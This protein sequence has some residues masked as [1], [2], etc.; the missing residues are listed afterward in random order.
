MDPS[1]PYRVNIIVVNRLF[2]R[3]QPR[4]AALVVLVVLAVLAYLPAQFLPPISDDYEQVSVSRRYGS[5]EN[6]D[7][8]LRDP[9]Y[10]CRSVS[11]V[12]TWWLEKLGGFAIL[13]AL[14]LLFHIL[15]TF[16]V[17]ALGL[18]HRIGWRISLPAAAFF[19][20]AEGHQEAVIWYAALPELNVFTFTMLAFL[21][22]IL[23][24]ERGGARY[25]AG[26]A[27]AFLVAL[28]SKESAAALV[29][30]QV[31]AIMIVD[32]R[33]VR[34]WTATV[35]FAATAVL[36]FAW[37]YTARSTHLH[38][39]DGTFSL[40]APFVLTLLNSLGRMFWFW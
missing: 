10:R 8:L 25:Y 23:W 30:L 39:N 33:R 5:F 20:V 24:L 21:C 29:G 7:S 6:W 37:G 9:L 16:L 35:P 3:G 34:F 36:Y 32:A 27:A 15:N 14:S 13:N 22:W 38:Y 17:A 40:Q 28:L 18:W 19:A 31:L 12:L 11:I 4:P 26:A 1:W 2:D